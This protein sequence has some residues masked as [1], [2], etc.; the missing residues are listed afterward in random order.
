MKYSRNIDILLP[1]IIYLGSHE[2][3][4]ARSPE[5][6]SKELS[7]DQ[8]RLSKVFN[9]FPEIFRKTIPNDDS[10]TTYYA[11]QARYAQREG[12]DTAD[13]SKLSYIRELDREH[14]KMLIDFVSQSSER[15]KAGRRAWTTVTSAIIAAASALIVALIK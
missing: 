5:S 9:D 1:S 12:G 13:P 11:L 15:E 10:D 4:W 7:L 14:I 3:Y 6:M 8:D 2:Y